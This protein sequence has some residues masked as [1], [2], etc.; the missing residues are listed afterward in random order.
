ME[1]GG[2]TA[3]YTGNRLEKFIEHTLN[4]LGYKFVDKKKFEPA[5]YLEQPIYSKQFYVGKSIYETSMYCD[6]ILYHPTKHKDCLIIESKWQQSKGSVDEKYPYLILN[7]QHKHPNK[8]ILVI[9]GGGYK[10]NALKW[11]HSQVGNNLLGV[12]NMSEFQIWANKGKI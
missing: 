6:F 3:N 8:T 5:I 12:F 2:T 10:E 1:Q 11:L 4:E 7:I 9:D